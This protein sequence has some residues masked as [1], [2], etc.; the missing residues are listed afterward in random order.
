MSDT[1]YDDR[2]TGTETVQHFSN[3]LHFFLRQLPVRGLGVRFQVHLDFL[4][5]NLR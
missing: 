4:T 3:M 1:W 5:G 2:M